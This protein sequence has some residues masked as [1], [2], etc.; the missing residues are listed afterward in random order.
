MGKGGGDLPLAKGCFLSEM[1]FF[2]TI[3]LETGMGM[4]SIVKGRDLSNE[5]FLGW[6]GREEVGLFLKVR[7]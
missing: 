2:F 3:P 4:V 7:G 6:L 1:G 5:L